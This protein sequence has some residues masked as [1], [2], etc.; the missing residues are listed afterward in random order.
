MQ[1]FDGPCESECFRRKIRFV[2]FSIMRKHV[3]GDRMVTNY[4]RKRLNIQNEKNWSKDRALGDPTSQKR[5]RGFYF[6]YSYYLYP[7]LQVRSKEGQSK[8][9]KTKSVFEANQNDVMIDSV[10]SSA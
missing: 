10:E 9:A 3:M 5:R 7:I 1:S 6:I 4:T 8:I 2:Q